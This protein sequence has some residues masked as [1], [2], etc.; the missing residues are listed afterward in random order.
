[1]TPPAQQPSG[2]ST[3]THKR[4][5][6]RVRLTTR[7]CHTT[8]SHD[9]TQLH[10]ARSHR[11]RRSSTDCT[12]RLTRACSSAA[13]TARSS[14]C[15]LRSSCFGHRASSCDNQ[16]ACMSRARQY[17]PPGVGAGRSR[18]QKCN[19]VVARALHSSTNKLAGPQPHQ[20]RPHRHGCLRWAVDSAP[21]STPAAPAPA[22][23]SAHSI[24]H[25]V[26]SA[27]FYTHHGNNNN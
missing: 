24:A 10:I 4:T 6:A 21:S 12:R 25:R 23:L 2:S 8:R 7:G 20:S 22:P 14:K 27:S 19:A 18:R 15:R 16:C 3:R 11:S 5:R 9:H 13:P 26:A 17:A 1:M